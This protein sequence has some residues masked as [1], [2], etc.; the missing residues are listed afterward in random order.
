MANIPRRLQGHPNIPHLTVQAAPPI[1]DTAYFTMSTSRPN[2]TVRALLGPDIPQITDGYG[3]FEEYERPQRRAG[4]EWTGHPVL[5]MTIADAILDGWW[6]KSGNV[7]RHIDISQRITA[8]NR[9][10]TSPGAGVP[11][12]IVKVKGSAIL[13]QDVRWAINGLS[14]GEA[15]RTVDQ[16]LYV[17]QAFTVEFIQVPLVGQV[18]ELAARLAGSSGSASAGDYVVQ[19]GDSL[20][21]IALKKLGDVDKWRDIAELNNIQDTRRLN[22]GD[23]LRLP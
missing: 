8:L 10:A 7:Y 6:V 9:M 5:K 13:R 18:S 14:F 21:S 4:V 12:P 1:P 15:I 3:G 16:G 23:T 22:T 11:P 20:R 19:N 2:L 17:R